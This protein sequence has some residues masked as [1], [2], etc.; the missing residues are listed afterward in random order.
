MNTMKPMPPHLPKK[1]K[2]EILHTQKHSL[3]YFLSAAFISIAASL[4]TVFVA[5]SWIVP[6]AVPQVQF[7]NFPHE[8]LA[9]NLAVSQ[10][11]QNRIADREVILYDKRT[12]LAGGWY[13]E[14]GAL[15]NG[16]FL[17][18]DGWA[19][20]PLTTSTQIEK[21]NLSMFQVIDNRGVS[22]TVDKIVVDKTFH[23]AYAKV[24][25]VGFHFVSFAN[26]DLLKLDQRVIG[27]KNNT[28]DF[29]I[30]SSLKKNSELGQ[31]AE[32]WKPHSLFHLQK[33]ELGMVFTEQGEFLAVHQSNGVLP[34]WYI[35]NALASL[36]SK[37][38]L[39]YGAFPWKGE[40]VSHTFQNGFFKNITGFFVTDV[41]G[42]K[43]K[44]GIKVGDVIVKVQGQELTPHNFTR[45]FI[46]GP[47]NVS[48][49]IIRDGSTIQKT[50]SKQIIF[51][52]AQG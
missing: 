30:F 11:L 47:D 48:L 17:T 9:P 33:S 28:Y 44:E 46:E 29:D 20:F 31:N 4:S 5:L 1:E 14:G 39:S 32:I 10:D 19:V 37:Q 49:E 41:N 13:A 43:T 8:T 25:G 26:W 40:V 50:L 38:S 45:L 18:S 23:L 24:N 42:D 15:S 21:I 52:S 27:K 35:Q 22:Y 16:V 51:L 34:G 36:L 6:R 7:Y 12:Q 2:Q 3:F